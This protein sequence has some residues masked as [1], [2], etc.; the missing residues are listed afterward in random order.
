MGAR[1]LMSSLIRYLDLLLVAIALPIFLIADL[2]MAG[3]GVGSG[4]WVAQRGLQAYTNHRARTSEDPRTV[5][6]V[7]AGSMI[8]RGWLVAIAIFLVG[9]SENSAGLASALLVITLF[10]VY[11]TIGMI[12][13]PFESGANTSATGG[14]QASGVGGGAI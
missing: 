4:A 1:E 12:F 8:A 7:L 9:L 11:F 14:Q 3:W 5:V 13:R 6:G 10:T 2:P